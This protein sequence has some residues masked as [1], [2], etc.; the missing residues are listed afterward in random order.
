MDIRTK[1]VFALVAVTLGSMLVFGTFMY[2]IADRMVSDGAE[3]QLE[4]MASSGVDAVG[5]IAKGW[6]ER[7]QLVASRT[8]LRV[9]LKEV[10]DSADSAAVVRIER[11]LMDAANSV[12]IVAALGVY[13]V[14]GGIV[15]RAGQEA[16]SIP[17][18]LSERS[19]AAPADSVTFLGVQSVDKKY[20]QIVFTTPLSLERERI[21]YLYVLLNGSRIAE[22]GTDYTGL[23]KT[24]ELMIVEPSPTGARTLHRVRHGEGDAAV[25]PILL[26]GED[27][28]A[29]L[30]LAGVEGVYTD[31]IRDYRDEEVWA[32]TGYV[33]STGWGVV[34]KFDSDEKK[35]SIYEFRA[36]LITL[37]LGL[38]GIG[39]LVALFLG[40]RLSAPIHDLARVADRI[41]DGDLSARASRTREDE[42]GLLA[43][44]FNDMAAELQVRM[45]ELREY[46]KFFDASID[47]LCIAGTDGYFKRT[48]PAFVEALG[49]SDEELTGQPFMDLVHPEDAAAT[50][51]EID[52]LALGVPTISF[53]NRF[54][55]SDGTW[56]YL[57]WN[58]Y[59]D[60]ASGLLYAIA[61][62]I[63]DPQEA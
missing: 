10:D 11:I 29:R 32:A 54:R 20:P 39:L 6:K 5:D 41:R 21:G 8:Q 2:V 14:R 24:G 60:P 19:L 33:P 37:A 45:T 16:S 25:G 15:A 26:E 56:K 47:L 58:S 1:L 53:V 61:R 44:T 35:A 48:N 50:Q 59:P 38:S 40:F 62:Q 22:L 34:A 63:K 31:G 18:S 23:G 49:W 27:D 30:A 51:N 52:K 28:P 9:S 12:R 7:V 4:G 13:D 55:C 46:Q 36:E 57:R 43:H 42:I 3:A 17:G